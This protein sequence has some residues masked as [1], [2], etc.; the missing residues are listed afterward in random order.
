[1]IFWHFKI[2]CLLKSFEEQIQLIYGFVPQHFAHSHHMAVFVTVLAACRLG[3]LWNP[4]STKHLK[5]RSG[6][7]ANCGHVATAAAHQFIGP[8]ASYWCCL[9]MCIWLL[10]TNQA[11]WSCCGLSHSDCRQVALARALRLLSLVGSG[12]T[13]VC[14]LNKDWSLLLKQGLGRPWQQPANAPTW[15]GSDGLDLSLASRL[16]SAGLE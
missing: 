7:Q 12:E 6:P 15:L 4:V 10:Q 13:G 16:G 1:M 9:V 14:F 8:N 11:A 2:H 3:P 5:S